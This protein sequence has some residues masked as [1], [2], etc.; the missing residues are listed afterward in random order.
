MRYIF[1]EIIDRRLAKQSPRNVRNASA[2]QDLRRLASM[3]FQLSRKG[4]F[5]CGNRK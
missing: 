2:L 3:A 1:L 5:K 4:C